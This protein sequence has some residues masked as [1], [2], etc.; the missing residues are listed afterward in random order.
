M[1]LWFIKTKNIKKILLSST[2]LIII[3]NNRHK[4]INVKKNY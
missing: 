2:I 1:T 4:K 3:F